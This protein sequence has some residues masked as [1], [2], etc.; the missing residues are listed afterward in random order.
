M[1]KKNEKDTIKI[2]KDK[3]SKGK[4][5]KAIPYM[6]VSLIAINVIISTVL[7]CAVKG[8]VDSYYGIL[9]DYLGLVS[10]RVRDGELWRFFTAIFIHF[11]LKHLGYN[12]IALY[13]FGPLY[14]KEEGRLKILFVYLVAGIFG[15]IISFAFNSEFSGGASG[16][17]FGLIG[18]F[19]A[20]I[21][22]DMLL[23]KSKMKTTV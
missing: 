18:L 13:S 7:F 21:V 15:N 1:V 4:V 19:S 2:K 3:N 23:V 10:P 12:M 14:E 9:Y 17:I 8:N 16:A 11:D 22:Q 20:E 6:T 5:K